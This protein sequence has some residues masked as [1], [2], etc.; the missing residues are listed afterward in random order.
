MIVTL[1]LQALLDQPVEQGPTVVAECEPFVVVH[2]KP[3]WYIETEALPDGLCREKW[4]A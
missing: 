4:N 2:D 1:T 3:V